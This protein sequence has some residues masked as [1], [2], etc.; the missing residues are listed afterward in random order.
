MKDDGPDPSA[1]F[2]CQPY[3]YATK[4]DLSICEMLSPEVTRLGLFT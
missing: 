2:E 3:Y 1:G 4:G